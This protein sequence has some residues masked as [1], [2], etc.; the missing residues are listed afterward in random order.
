MKRRGYALATRSSDIE[1]LLSRLQANYN[2]QPN[3]VCIHNGPNAAAGAYQAPHSDDWQ[4]PVD[5]VDLLCEQTLIKPTFGHF[6]SHIKHVLHIHTAGI[7]IVSKWAN[8]CC[9]RLLGR[10]KTITKQDQYHLEIVTPEGTNRQKAQKVI[11][12]AG[13]YLGEIGSMLGVALPVENVFHQKLAF[14]DHLA[15]V[16]RNQLFSVDMDETTLVWATEA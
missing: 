7:L 4:S 14:E 3:M 9:N 12:A 15:A 6:S 5:G 13:P 8:L 16:P 10:V 1:H 11:N 2:Q